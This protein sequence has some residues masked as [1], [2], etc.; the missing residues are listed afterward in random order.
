MRGLRNAMQV[1]VNTVRTARDQ[2][3]AHKQELEATRL[4][5]R[6]RTEELATARRQQHAT[7]MQVRKQQDHLEGD[8]SDISEKIA[9][10]LAQQAGVLPA[11]PIRPGA[12]GLIWPVNGPVVSGFGPRWGSF[13]EG[14]D[15][16][17]PTGTSIRAAA[18]GSVSIAGSVGGY[19]NYTCVDHGGGLST[20][21][22]HQERILVSV[23]QEVAQAQVIGVSDCTGH[24]LGPHVH[25]EV[26]VN[27]QAVDP[28]GYL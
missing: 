23:G 10:Q 24:C 28:L 9:E 16:A 27:G 15:I 20:C 18:S 14:I 7:L 26:R 12:H 25:F 21:Y 3:A 8:V 6:Q 1:T 11:G 2:I 19:G 4:R 13:H 17:V 22:A 5:L